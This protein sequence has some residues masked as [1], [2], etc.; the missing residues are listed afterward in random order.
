MGQCRGCA[1]VFVCICMR[2]HMCVG[3]CICAFLCIGCCVHFGTGLLGTSACAGVLLY[4]TLFDTS[5]YTSA[6]HSL[7]G[8]HICVYAYIHVCA[9]ISICLRMCVYDIA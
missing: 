6:T 8:A 7:Q 5:S 9:C 2:M 3:I 4:N 1:C